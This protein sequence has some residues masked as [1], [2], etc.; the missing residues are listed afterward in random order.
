MAV[1]TATNGNVQLAPGELVNTPASTFAVA[2]LFYRAGTT[3]DGYE[4]LTALATGGGQVITTIGADAGAEPYQVQM[5]HGGQTRTFGFDDLNDD[6]AYL[7]YV[8]KPDGVALP[9]ANLYRF[10][11]GTPGWDGWADGSD[12]LENRADVIALA[13]LLNQNGG[14]PWNGGIYVAAW[15]ETPPSE[16]DVTDSVTGL[17]IGVQQW[18]DSGPVALWRPGETDPVADEHLFP[19]AGSANETSSASVTVVDVDPLNFNMDFGGAEVITGTL[20]AELPAVTSALVGAATAD[21]ELAVTLPSVVAALVGAV[22]VSGDVDAQLPAVD[23]ALVGAVG[24]SGEL[25]IT[26][27]EVAGALVGS[28]AAGGV[29]DV[30][31]PAAVAAL[32]GDVAVSDGTLNVT[33]PEAVAALDGSTATSGTLD[34]VLPTVVAAAEGVIAEPVTGELEVALPSITA[35]LVGTSSATPPTPGVNLMTLAFTI[36]TGVGEC[37]REELAETEAG[38]PDRF[39]LIVPGEIA[40]DECECGQFAQSITT[41]VPS[42][43]FPFPSTDR[44]TT[45][46]GPQF[47]V[48]TVVASLTRC[49]PTFDRNNRAP[50]CDS[51]FAAAL[52]LEEDRGALRRGVT[53]CLRAMRNTYTS[54]IRITDFTVGAATSVGPNGTCAGVE[55]TYQFAVSNVCC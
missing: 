14:F 4:A 52:R 19:A 51:L 2:A 31:L 54:P 28:V 45:A 29:L 22:T 23:A 18:L 46:C 11:A 17:H 33:L 10:N 48:V 43:N 47:L 35:A 30:D 34:V 24:S 40:W 42:E 39:C 16:A 1:L 26:L 8:H 27:P 50:S 41:E 55:L 21:G 15:W 32:D 20:A 9:R 25:D 7:F 37:V 44:R 3:T 53:C 38:V 13:W 12:T 5:S 6:E 36:V 49:V